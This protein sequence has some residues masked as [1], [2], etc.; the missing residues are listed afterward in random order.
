MLRAPL[1]FGSG[2]ARDLSRPGAGSWGPPCGAHVNLLLI[3]R[4]GGQYGSRRSVGESPRQPPLHGDRTGMV[5]SRSR[6]PRGHSPC[7]HS[8]HGVR[9]HRHTQ[10]AGTPRSR[11]G[12]TPVR[13][14]GG[15]KSHPAGGART[16]TRTDAWMDE[17]AAWVTA[18]PHSA[19]HV[20]RETSSDSLG[21]PEGG[22]LSEDAGHVQVSLLAG[23]RLH[24]QRPCW[25]HLAGIQ[26]GPPTQQGPAGKQ[27]LKPK[28]PPLCA[29]RPGA[30]AL[31]PPLCGCCYNG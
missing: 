10:E 6:E 20:L 12:R 14:K 2:P 15:E 28:W 31:W 9:L 7:V 23:L 25:E 17:G 26:T 11:R 27:N 3:P 5:V 16:D 21:C 1:T 22:R 24:R 29:P 4:A 8:L 19:A 18:A 13:T 30:P